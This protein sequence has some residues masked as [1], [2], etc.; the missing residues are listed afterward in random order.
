MLNASLDGTKSK[1]FD[2]FE[3]NEK[4]IKNKEQS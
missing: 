4:M 3:R 2:W 1:V